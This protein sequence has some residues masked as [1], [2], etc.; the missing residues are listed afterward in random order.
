MRQKGPGQGAFEACRGVPCSPGEA[1]ISAEQ[2]VK[3]LGFETS[4]DAVN[5]NRGCFS[6]LRAAMDAEGGKFVGSPGPRRRAR[7]RRMPWSTV[8]R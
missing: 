6:A 1:K 8:L 5:K 3:P 4:G 7:R 2:A